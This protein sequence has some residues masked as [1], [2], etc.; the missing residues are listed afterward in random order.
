MRKHFAADTESAL[1]TDWFDV[2]I[3]I[4]HNIRVYLDR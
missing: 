2:F 3:H 4:V 1:V